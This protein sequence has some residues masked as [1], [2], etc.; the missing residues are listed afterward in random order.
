MSFLFGLYIC[1]VMS[2]S[3][4]FSFAFRYAVASRTLNSVRVEN[5][6]A[7]VSQASLVQVK[8]V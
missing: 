5:F 4:P 1:L 3:Q 7:I 6:L 2:S 8:F